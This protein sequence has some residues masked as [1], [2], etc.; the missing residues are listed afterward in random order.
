MEIRLLA[1]SSSRPD[2]HVVYFRLDD[3]IL[4]ITC[5]CEA[6][7]NGL[8][9]KHRLVLASGDQRMLYDQG[10]NEL[11]STAASWAQSSELVTLLE[12]AESAAMEVE[13][14]KNALRSLK[15]QMGRTM[16]SGLKP[17]GAAA[18]GTAEEMKEIMS[19]IAP[20][21]AEFLRGEPS[22]S[23]SNREKHSPPY[24]TLQGEAVGENPAVAGKTFVLTGTLERY[25]R[26]EAAR[27]I[28]SQGGRVTG[29][30]SGK[31]DYVVA[32]TDPGS[33]LDKARGLGVAVLSE[34]DF[35]KLVGT[36]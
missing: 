23:A 18:T 20:A 1:K 3:G 14:A 21:A 34:Q 33:K 26:D 4:R 29:S 5:D 10:Q 11:L 35:E 28:E 16:V 8:A 24:V 12:D 7:V 32:G 6:A 31:T 2:P 22:G 13:A 17:F 27:L 25:S 19:D 30:V 36:R 9:C 15:M